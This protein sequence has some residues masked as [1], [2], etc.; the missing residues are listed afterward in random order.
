MS[1]IYT[2]YELI[3]EMALGRI[4]NGTKIIPHYLNNDCTVKYF[5]YSYGFLEAHYK[6]NR[7]NDSDVNVCVFL[8]NNRTFEVIEDEIDI[9]NIK[10]LYINDKTK[11]VGKDAI[12]NW[13]GRNLDIT[14]S[15]KIN[16]ILQAVKQIDKRVKKLEGK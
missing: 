3:K 6:D 1:K 8:D 4:E 9:D 13:T 12:A 11:S 16:E 2:G 10:E 15:N 14:F 5:E 7:C